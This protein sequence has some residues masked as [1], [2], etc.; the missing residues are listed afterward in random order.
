[1][2][3]VMRLVLC[4][5]LTACTWGTYDENADGSTP[6]DSSVDADSGPAGVLINSSTGGVVTSS[7]G[8]FTATFPPGSLNGNSNVSI[9]IVSLPSFCQSK[10]LSCWKSAYT[11]TMA[12]T[13]QFTTQVVG[14]I[15]LAFHLSA[16]SFV[17]V[18][19]QTVIVKPNQQAMPGVWDDNGDVTGFQ[20]SDQ[21]TS[22]LGPYV[23][24]S[25][26]GFV[27]AKTACSVSS[28]DV[29]GG[30]GDGC[31]VSPMS[32]APSMG[33]G[34]SCMCPGNAQTESCIGSCITSGGPT[35]LTCP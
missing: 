28:S 26:A 24:T 19:T 17:V 32:P 29:C 31:C 20:G 16:S 13:Q 11:I 23:I 33:V 18:Q 14:T 34:T 10:G 22:K 1:M 25:A 5:C 35:S 8:L 27:N 6:S 15:R 2:F 4:A 21:T 3:G 9:A 7:D 30:C 12:S